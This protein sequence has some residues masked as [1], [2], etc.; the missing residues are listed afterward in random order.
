MFIRSRTNALSAAVVQVWPSCRSC[1][2]ACVGHGAMCVACAS[3]DTP[4]CCCL[5]VTFTLHLLYAGGC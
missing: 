4:A 5:A 3:T 1:T 2:A